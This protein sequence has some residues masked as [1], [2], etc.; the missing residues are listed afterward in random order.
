MRL[1][2]KVGEVFILIACWGVCWHTFDRWDHGQGQEG[3]TCKKL[4]VAREGEVSLIEKIA[5]RGFVLQKDGE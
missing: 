3:G 5:E 2:Y 1:S 4:H